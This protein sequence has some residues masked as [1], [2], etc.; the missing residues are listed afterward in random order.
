MTDPLLQ[1]VLDALTIKADVTLWAT[2][3]DRQTVRR[4]I[5][6]L[7]ERLAQKDAEPVAEVM[8]HPDGYLYQKWFQ[9]DPTTAFPKGTRFYAAPPVPAAVPINMILHC[10]KCGLQHVDAPDADIPGQVVRDGKLVSVPCVIKANDPSAW[11]NPPHR[12][13]LCHGCGHIW[14]PADVP[15][16]GVA[17]IKT[18]GKA[19]SPRVDPRQA[20]EDAAM[21]DW[22]VKERLLFAWV[23]DYR[24][25]NYTT[26]RAIG[27]RNIVGVETTDVRGA[28][29]AAMAKEKS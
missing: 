20:F 22:L 17:A 29:R 19:D 26:L 10:P 15:T 27:D 2:D 8:Q 3:E 23:T 12:S 16:N 21:L 13:H 6:A 11:T 25:G 4:T 14:R 28:I 1:Q 7:R 9:A 18:K 5:A 24:D